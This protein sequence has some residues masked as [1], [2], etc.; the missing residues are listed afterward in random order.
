M[1]STLEN[2]HFF[3]HGFYEWISP[4]LFN[5]PFM[6]HPEFGKEEG[7]KEEKSSAK[8]GEWECKTQAKG[9]VSRRTDKK[10]TGEA[11]KA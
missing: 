5:R 10:P 1:V 3:Q 4:E 6:S 2:S 8:E 7:R 11:T 9:G